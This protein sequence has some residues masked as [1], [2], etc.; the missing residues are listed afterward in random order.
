MSGRCSSVAARIQQD[1]ARAL[2]VCCMGH[3]LNLAVQDTSR[4]VKVMADTFD[5][6]P[7]LATVLK[8][9]IKKKT[10]L[11]KPNTDF[12]SETMGIR[13]LSPTRWTIRAELLRSV[14]YNYSVIHSVLEELHEIEE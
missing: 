1:E 8:Y 7:Q 11:L 4:S 3:S 10:M 14:I 6:I 2:Y 9:S 12:S 5:T 13:P